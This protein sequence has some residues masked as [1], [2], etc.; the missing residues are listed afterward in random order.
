MKHKFL[1]FL[2]LTLILKQTS[3]LTCYLCYHCE[4]ID[5]NSNTTTCLSSDNSC[6]TVLA[7]GKGFEMEEIQIVDRIC[8]HEYDV[9]YCDMLTSQLIHTQTC[10]MFSC[11]E[12]LCNSRTVDSLLSETFDR[13]T[14]KP[15]TLITMANIREPEEEEEKEEYRESRGSFQRGTVE[16]FLFF[17]MIM[18]RFVL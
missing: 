13:P 10:K 4:Y 1:Y 12:D 16:L 18:N 15:T 9:W 17:F 6:V 7:A 11:E 5:E 2:Y 3:Q 14:S 8:E